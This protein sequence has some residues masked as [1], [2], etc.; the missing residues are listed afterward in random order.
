MKRRNP[1][2]CLATYNTDTLQQLTV[3]QEY[4][5]PET[6]ARGTL[7]SCPIPKVQA[8]AERNQR[9][10]CNSAAFQL[11]FVVLNL[12]ASSKQQCGA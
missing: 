10:W 5:H 6:I 4:K 1:L 3:A 12:L 7:Y 2:I 9:V 8:V 11:Y